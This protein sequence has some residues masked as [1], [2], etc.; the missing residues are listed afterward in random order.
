MKESVKQSDV[1]IRNLQDFFSRRADF[2]HV[3]MAFLYGSRA[4][5][6][7]RKDSDI[8]LAVLFE[9]DIISDDKVFDLITRISVCLSREMKRITNVIPIYS[10]FR[11]PMLYYNV[12]VKGVPLYIKDDS[13]YLNLR[14]EALYQMEDFEIFGRGWQI[15]ISRKNLEGLGDGGI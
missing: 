15:L 10:D 7:P 5:G 11:K 12:I 4:D 3:D 1:L 8:D 13:K 6:I 9:D 2:F 14:N